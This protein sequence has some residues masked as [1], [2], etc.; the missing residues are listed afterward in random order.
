MGNFCLAKLGLALVR[1]GENEADENDSW[2]L[3]S[4]KQNQSAN[5]DKSQESGHHDYS[6]YK[7]VELN[8]SR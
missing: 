8:K 6:P 1:E 2:S 5:P 3:E 7:Q 4:V